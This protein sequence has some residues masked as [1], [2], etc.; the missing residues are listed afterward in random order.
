MKNSRLFNFS[1]LLF[2]QALLYMT[3]AGQTTLFR[4]TFDDGDLTKNTP[5]QFFYGDSL[6][7]S[8]STLYHSA[9]FSCKISTVNQLSAIENNTRIFKVDMPFELTEYVYVDTLK[10]EAIPWLLRGN[11]TVMVLFLLPKG[12]VQ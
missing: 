7:S 12:T 2:F 11:A 5:W 8:D 6:I 3:A 4:E 10:D 1:F 9:H